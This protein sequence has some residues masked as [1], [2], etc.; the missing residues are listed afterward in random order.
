MILAQKGK[1]SVAQAI[2]DSNEDSTNVIQ[3]PAVDYVA[4]TDLWW[5]V[6]TVVIAATAGTLDFSLVLSKE[7]T[8]DINLVICKMSIAAITDLRVATVGRHIIAV[9][10]GK[11][12]K[13]MAETD[14][15]DY[16]YVG[17]LNA[18]SA[19]TTITINAALSPTEPQTLHHK[20]VITSPVGVP[21]IASVGSGE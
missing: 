1:L 17:Q 20:M 18:L 4:M 11:M 21:A 7:S 9:N 3:I 6:D 10:V 14:G 5:V 15:S 2:T 13:E 12:I 8:L 16:V 19:S